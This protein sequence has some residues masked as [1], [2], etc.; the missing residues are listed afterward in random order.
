MP[1]NVMRPSQWCAVCG[2][3]IRGYP[4]AACGGSGHEPPGESVRYASCESLI[5]TLKREEI[6]ANEY[7]NLEDLR[8]HIEEFIERYQK[9]L[10]SALGYRSPEE[11]LPFNFSCLAYL[12]SANLFHCRSPLSLALTAR[13]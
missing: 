3:G 5:K 10:H 13:R 11:F 6:Y 8:D 4:E 12:C 1:V 2:G 7:A 9:R